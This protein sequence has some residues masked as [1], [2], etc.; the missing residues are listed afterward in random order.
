M[1]TATYSPDDNKLRL[2]AS[3]R[4]SD[5]EWKRLKNGGFRWASKQEL[6][7]APRWTPHREDLLLEL[8]D[9]IEDED[10]SKEE[11]SADRADR[12][13]DYRDKRRREAGGHADTFEA[14]P[15]SF[16]HQNRQ[17]AERQAARHDRHR[18][19][20]CSQWSKAVYW[21]ERTERVISHALYKARPEVRRGRILRLEAD[22]RRH[23]GERWKTHYALSLA[24]ERA[25]LENEGG[26]VAEVDMIPGGFIGSFQIQ[27]VHKSNTTGRVVSV[28]VLARTRCSFKRDGSPMDPNTLT[29]QNLNIQRFG[30]DAYR[31]PTDEEMK[32]FQA[33]R[34]EEKAKAKTRNKANPKP[35]LITQPTRTPRG[36]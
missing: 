23:S 18:G 12:F 33:K 10:Q 29:L 7:V 5:E 24:Y 3:V 27:R 21:Q 20:A 35:K 31:A 16:G 15:S 9:E 34:A 19:R 26:S 17:R 6:F 36:C 11:R 14:G 30:T 32:I 8:C 22:E 28:T 1:Y 25:M 13:S 2:Y 4:L